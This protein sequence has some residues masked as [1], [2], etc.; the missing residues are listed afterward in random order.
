MGLNLN[1]IKW[2]GNEDVFNQCNHENQWV[3]GEKFQ[4]LR[5]GKNIIQPTFKFGGGH[6]VWIWFGEPGSTN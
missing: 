4:S 1:A 3:V 5:I 6:E 2:L